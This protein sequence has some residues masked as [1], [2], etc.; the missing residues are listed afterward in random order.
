M[1]LITAIYVIATI[2]ISNANIRS[3]EATREQVIE[4]RQQFAES[5]HLQTMPF[6]QLEIP[7]EQ[8]TPL[9]EIELDL[10]DGDTSDTLYKIVK[11]KCEFRKN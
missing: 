11:L 3:A 8:T 6:L 10:C 1:V 2:N 5:K 7:I 9:F 4:S